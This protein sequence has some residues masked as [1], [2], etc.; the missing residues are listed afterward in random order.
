MPVQALLMGRR[1]LNV[2]MH[3]DSVRSEAAPCQKRIL[4]AL[5][6]S[7]PSKPIQSNVAKIAAP[8]PVHV[9]T[10]TNCES[11]RPLLGFVLS[12]AS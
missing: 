9:I 1:I 6:N 3:R 11:I 4:M 5:M 7:Q 10:V 12:A 2:G 8:T